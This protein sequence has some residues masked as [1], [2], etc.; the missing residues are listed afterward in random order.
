M[1]PELYFEQFK[2]VLRIRD[3]YPLSITDPGL[4]SNNNKRGRGRNYS[5]KLE[6]DRIFYL[7]VKEKI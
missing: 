3:V 7:Q 1:L 6:K 2:A 4:R 5:Q